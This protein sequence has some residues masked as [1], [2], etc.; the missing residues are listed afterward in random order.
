MLAVLL[1]TLSDSLVTR[2][3]VAVI[4]NKEVT[5]ITHDI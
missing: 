5:I 2:S 1:F 3:K 4:W